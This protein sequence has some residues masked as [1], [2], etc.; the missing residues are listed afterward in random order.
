[1]LPCVRLDPIRRTR[2]LF[3]VMN[4]PLA[5]SLLLTPT[6]LRAFSVLNRPPPSYDGHVPLTR[7]ERGALAV[8]SALGAFVD[9][10]RAGTFLQA[11]L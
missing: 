10:R 6:C 3:I 7:T 11:S 9:P 2:T 8:G 1:M 4:F 5:H